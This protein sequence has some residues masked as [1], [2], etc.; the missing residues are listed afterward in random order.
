MAESEGNAGQACMFLPLKK[1]GFDLEAAMNKTWKVSDG[2]GYADTASFMLGNA[3]LSFSDITADTVKV[4]INASLAET[5][6]TSAKSRTYNNSM[7]RSGNFL[8]FE[9]SDKT[10]YNLAFISDTEAFLSIK[11]TNEC[12]VLRFNTANH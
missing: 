8:S 5:D 12:F 3:S 9:D 6:G 7:K 10:A 2:G 11:N 4:N 1:A